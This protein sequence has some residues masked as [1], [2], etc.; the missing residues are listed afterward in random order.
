MHLPAL[1][2]SQHTATV[3]LFARPSRRRS[4]ATLLG[5]DVHQRPV[6]QQH[7]HALLCH[8]PPHPSTRRPQT[9]NSP[10]RAARLRPARRD[11]ESGQRSSKPTA[12]LTHS[13]WPAGRAQ[14]GEEVRA[15]TG[16]SAARCRGVTPSLSCRR[17]RGAAVSRARGVRHSPADSGFRAHDPQSATLPPDGALNN[18]HST[19]HEGPEDLQAGSANAA[20][21]L[22]AAASYGL[23][24]GGLPLACVEKACKSWMR[25]EHGRGR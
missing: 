8:R 4:R 6:H 18:R 12:R 14:W 23:R 9:I 22:G 25:M 24:R 1:R 2:R 10:Q 3:L 13:M 15:Q 19:W 11:V 5:E 16:F 20:A 7:L 17:R 21:V